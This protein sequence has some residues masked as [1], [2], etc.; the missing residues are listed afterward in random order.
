M[1]KSSL[2]SKTRYEKRT[3]VGAVNSSMVPNSIGLD[4][5]RRTGTG[6]QTIKMADD[7]TAEELT[8]PVRL[9]RSLQY[10]NIKTIVLKN[11]PS[12][13]TVCEFQERVDKG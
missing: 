3:D 5:E 6:L 2:G 7:S 10:R 9:I 4:S 11:I 12:N 13:I 1:S 8:I